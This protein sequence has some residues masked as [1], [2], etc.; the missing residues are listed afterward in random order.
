MKDEDKGVLRASQ[1]DGA[2]LGLELGLA[3]SRAA[4]QTWRGPCQNGRLQP[5][6]SPAPE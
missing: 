2:G 5:F 6:N 3:S 4:L 1:L